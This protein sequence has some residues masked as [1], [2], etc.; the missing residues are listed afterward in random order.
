MTIF[1]YSLYVL[2]LGYD[3]AVANSNLLSMKFVQRFLSCVPA[4]PLFNTH[5]LLNVKVVFSN[6]K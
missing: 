5:S 3:R 1:L 2:S 4:I 6:I